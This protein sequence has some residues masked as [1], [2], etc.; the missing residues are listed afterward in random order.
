MNKKDLR[1]KY[2]EL[3]EQL[4]VDEI[5]AKSMAITNRLLQLDTIPNGRQV[6]EQTYFHLFLSI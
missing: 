6:W 1:K 3:R 5:E 4:S 2:K